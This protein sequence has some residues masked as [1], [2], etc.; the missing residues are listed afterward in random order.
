M[1]GAATPER[2]G[3]DGVG[4]LFPARPFSGGGCYCRVSGAAAPK[5]GWAN[6][7]PGWGERGGAAPHCCRGMSVCRVW[8]R[9][10][11]QVPHWL[12][13]APSSWL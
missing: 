8:R 1:W 10:A 12:A 9:A 11:R 7:D 5:V 4:V 6:Q 2:A 3:D 13:V